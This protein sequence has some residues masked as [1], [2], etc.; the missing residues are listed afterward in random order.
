ME[1]EKKRKKA[2]YLPNTKKEIEADSYIFLVPNELVAL[3]IILLLKSQLPLFSHQPGTYL[4]NKMINSALE[5]GVENL[6]LIIKYFKLFYFFLFDIT[7][8]TKLPGA[9]LSVLVTQEGSVN[10]PPSSVQS[11]FV[12][13][14]YV[15]GTVPSHQ[16]EN[17]PEKKLV[18]HADYVI[19]NSPGVI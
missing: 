7:E 13:T 5:A 10:C 14:H 4:E 15:P 11:T 9:D 12:T 6:S 19:D 16:H 3:R 17:S 1:I 18:T 8:S 2:I